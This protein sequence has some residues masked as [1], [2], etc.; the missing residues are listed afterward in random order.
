MALRGRRLLVVGVLVLA[1]VSALAAGEAR[2]RPAA[3]QVDMVQM[4][5]VVPMRLWDDIGWLHRALEVAPDGR[6]RLDAIR[7]GG[8]RVPV[9]WANASASIG[10]TDEM[11][12]YAAR[13]YGGPYGGIKALV[14][15]RR[16]TPAERRLFTVEPLFTEADVLVAAPG[17]ELCTRG[18]T[19]SR[20]QALL[21]GTARGVRLAAPAAQGGGARPMFDVTPKGVTLL[22]EQTLA[23][24]V[25]AG[26]AAA[27]VGFQRARP[28]IESGRLCA[29]PVDG[30]APTVASVRAG[31]YPVSRPV[32]LAFVNAVWRSPRMGAY[33][34][35]VRTR[36]LQ[37]AR[38]PLGR[39]FLERAYGPG[40]LPGWRS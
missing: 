10:T 13:P 2:A 38:G 18:L 15:D 31:R 3:P 14:V 23:V 30:V 27:A 32:G 9:M 26:V 39:A 40:M 20:V 16:L 28:A 4:A 33:A 22:P 17:S 21:T 11:L 19:R 1:A 29:V 35:G 8:K 12:R 25:P 34:D 36:F 7:V 5:L 6:P 24:T 37:L